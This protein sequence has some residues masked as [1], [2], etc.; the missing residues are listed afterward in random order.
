M[1]DG[2]RVG[3]RPECDCHVAEL[4]QGRVGDDPLDVVLN[5]PQKAHEERGNR[6]DD[7]NKRKGDVAEFKQRTHACDHKDAS[8]HHRCRVNQGRDRGRAFHRIGQPDMQRELRALTHR[9]DKEADAS[10]SHQRPLNNAEIKHRCG[11]G[12]RHLEDGCVIKTAEVGKYQTNAEGKTEVTDAVDQERLEVGVNRGWPGEPETNQQIRDQSDC[13][14]AEE[15]LHKI[16]RHHEHQHREGK[17]ADVGEEA[18]VAGV[19]FHVTDGVD[20]D[21]QRHKG[22]DAHHGRGQRVDQE[23]NLKANASY[24]RPFVQHAVETLSGQRLEQH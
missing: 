4:G 12:R 5:D 6:S 15:E 18:L 21:H 23:P 20:V 1:E 11:F 22:H 13:F 24:S 2:C 8:G 14:P 7:D 17:Q 19:F 16:I 10:D 3:R 9:A